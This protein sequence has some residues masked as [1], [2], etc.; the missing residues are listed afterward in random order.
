LHDKIPSAQGPAFEASLV[1][2][3][4]T[5]PG[6]VRYRCVMALQSLAE[7]SGCGACRG[8]PPHA[9]AV[10]PSPGSHH[11][12]H[13]RTSAGGD[14]HKWPGQSLTAWLCFWSHL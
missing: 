2:Q 14:F 3:P 12:G 9:S 5:R 11:G 4:E 8:P 10:L 1:P 7:C 6:F 13:A